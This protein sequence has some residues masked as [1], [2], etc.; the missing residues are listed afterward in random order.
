METNPKT[1]ANQEIDQSEAII[2]KARAN[3]KS[4]MWASVAVVAVVAAILIYVFGIRQPGIKKAD[5]AAS[6]A[7]VEQNDSIAMS[8]YQDAAKLGYKSGNR[9]KAEVA[10]RLYQK[11]QYEEALKYLDD[12]DID[13][14]IVA[15]GIE[16]LK[17]DCYAN[18]E[19]YDKAIACYKDGVKI[20]DKNPNVVPLLLIKEANVYRAQ[21]NYEGEYQAYKQIVDEYPAYAQSAQIDFKKYMERAKASAGK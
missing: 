21:Q 18:L 1:N 3:K 20:A 12:A 19:Q 6:R 2:A 11:G 16:S 8:L 15:A 17:G 13:D 14:N 9:A 5:E 10:I 7:D 4:I